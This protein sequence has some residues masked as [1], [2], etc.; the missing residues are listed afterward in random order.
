MS[1]QNDVN[2]LNKLN[3]EIK[4]LSKEIKLLRKQAKEAEAR[5]VEFLRVK[6]TPGVKFQGKAIILESKE[7]HN[8]KK[9]IEQEI[10]AIEVLSK[11]GVNNPDEVL[12]EVLN[13]RKGSATEIHKLK[14]KTL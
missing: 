3:Q 12:K 7:K 9:K 2:E 6:E 13:A 4:R 11:Y 1:V 10:D 14:I 5:I 8:K